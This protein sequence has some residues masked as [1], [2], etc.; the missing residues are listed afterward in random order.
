M[1]EAGGSFFMNARLIFSIGLLVLYPALA[2]ANGGECPAYVAPEIS[3][4]PIFEEPQINHAFQIRELKMLSGGGAVTTEDQ[5]ALLTQ[6]SSR[7][8]GMTQYIFAPENRGTIQSHMTTYRGLTKFD[9][10]IQSNDVVTS[11][12]SA[13]NSICAQVS[14]IGLSLVVKD[15]TIYIGNEFPPDSCSYQTILEHELKHVETAKVFL[16]TFAPVVE[17][18]MRDFLGGLGVVHVRGDPSGQEAQNRIDRD[19]GAFVTS[20]SLELENALVLMQSKVDSR[21]E[22]ARVAQSCGGE[23]QRIFNQS[24]R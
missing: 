16:N 17:N 22:Y 23:T 18:R 24:A 10:A 2:R 21:E 14:T 7:V 6:E 1:G 8:G 19:L 9:P 11:H 5:K 15:A 13:S 20:L 12:S 4:T 3:V